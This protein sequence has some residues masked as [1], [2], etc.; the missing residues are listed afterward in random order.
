MKTLSALFPIL[1][2]IHVGIKFCFPDA[3]AFHSQ[4]EAPAMVIA[5]ELDATE[6]NPGVLSTS[7]LTAY[8]PE[9]LRR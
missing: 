9:R 1:L 3:F 2:L 7:T 5:A 4:N 6:P 8:S